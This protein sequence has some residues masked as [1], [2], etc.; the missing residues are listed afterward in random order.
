MN[1]GGRWIGKINVKSENINNN[2]NCENDE[3]N[4]EFR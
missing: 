1:I 3:N 4:R 2:K